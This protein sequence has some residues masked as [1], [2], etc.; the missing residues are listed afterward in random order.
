MSPDA[1]PS[2]LFADRLKAARLLRGWT[3]ADLAAR[4][5]LPPTSIAHFEAGS[6][7]PSFDNLRR[8]A[9]AL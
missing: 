1:K 9:T 7:K 4:A 2:D 3:Q 5:G 6:H 8:L